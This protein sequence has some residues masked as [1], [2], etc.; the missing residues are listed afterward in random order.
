MRVGETLE[1]VEKDVIIDK[2]AIFISADIAKG[3]KDRYVFYSPTM[4][5]ILSRWIDY[6]DRYLSTD[7]LFPSIKGNKMEVTNMEKNVLKVGLNSNIN[8][9]HFRSNFGKRV[10]TSGMSIYQLY[11]ILEHSSVEVTQAA[12]ADLTTE[13]IRKSYQL[14]S[15]LE[16]MLK[17]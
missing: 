5:K 4:Q 12:Y 11:V 8:C 9:H 10:L 7:L 16:N 14:H 2:R 17:K 15:P 13:D 6:K 1:L 3:K